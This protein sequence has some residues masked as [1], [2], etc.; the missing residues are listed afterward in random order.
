MRPEKCVVSAANS[1]AIVSADEHSADEHFADEHFADEHFADEHSA[2]EHSA[3]EHSAD[4][5][6]AD[7]HSAAPAVFRVSAVA[8]RLCALCSS[9][10]PIPR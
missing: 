2:D 3:D 9:D 7:E 5:H 8:L 10:Y 1:V 4:E 6:S